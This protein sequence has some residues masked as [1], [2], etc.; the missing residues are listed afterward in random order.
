MIKDIDLVGSYLKTLKDKGIPVIWRPLHEAGGRWFWWG[1]DAAA[2]QQPSTNSRIA[3]HPS[4][5]GKMHSIAITCY[6][7]MM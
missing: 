1:M 5:G 3:M 6:Q 2:C 4:V 7:E